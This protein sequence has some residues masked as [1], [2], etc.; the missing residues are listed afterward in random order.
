MWLRS[1]SLRSSIDRWLPAIFLPG[2]R[3]RFSPLSWRSRGS[4]LQTFV[5]FRT[6][7]CC[8]SYSKPRCSPVEGLSNVRWSSTATTGVQ[9]IRL[10]LLSCK[11]CL[12]SCRRSTVVIQLNWSSWTYQKHLTR[13]TRWFCFS[14]CKLLLASTTQLTGGFSLICFLVEHITYGAGF[15]NHQ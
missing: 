7:R 4:T 15:S 3:R 6:C 10:K 2:S 14:V 8:R 1:S 11:C 9:V 5:R 12:T 13:L